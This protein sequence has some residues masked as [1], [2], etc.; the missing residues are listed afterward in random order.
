MYELYIQQ[1]LNGLT[2]HF[3]SSYI[4]DGCR[5]QQST[6]HT[7][8]YGTTGSVFKIALYYLTQTTFEVTPF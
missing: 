2:Y 7:C 3:I 6:I 4:P 1:R 8:F 5:L